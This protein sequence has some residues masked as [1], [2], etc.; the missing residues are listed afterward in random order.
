MEYIFHTIILICIYGA[1]GASLNLIAGY[2]GMLSIAHASFF[3]VG[4]YTAAL[5]SLYAHTSF[6]VVA[7]SSIAVSC[8]A[9]TLLIAPSLRVK[10]DYFVIST[11]AF[12]VIAFQ[13]FNNW[14]G[15]TR[16]PM[17]LPG[18]PQ[19][20][21]GGFELSTP[22]RFFFLALGYLLVVHWIVAKIASSPLGRVLTAIREDEVL[23]GVAGKCA[24]TD[25]LLI[26][27]VGAGIAGGAGA[28]YAVYIGFIDPSSFTVMDSIFML[29]I[30]I[31][32]GAGSVWGPLVGAILLITIPEAL[33]FLGL[34]TALAADIRQLLYGGLLIVFLL[35]RPKGI[36]GHYVEERK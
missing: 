18:I 28:L 10:G 6:F 22:L 11:F 7:L 36:L 3:G 26:F 17:G 19:A 20:T 35:W 27:I 25:K 8:V 2:T 1:L 24:I 32:G 21:I 23:T 31:V 9:G 14:V 4:A 13:I 5:L 12:Q 30:L 34:P 29:S 15:L 33:R 16:G